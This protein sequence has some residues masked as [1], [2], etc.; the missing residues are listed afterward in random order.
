MMGGWSCGP[1]GTLFPVYE[2]DVCVPASV[3]VVTFTSGAVC[4][5]VCAHVCACSCVCARVCVWLHWPT[6]TQ[7]VC[8]FRPSPAS[9]LPGPCSRLAG[10][11]PFPDR[12]GCSLRTEMEPGSPEGNRAQRKGWRWRVVEALPAPPGTL[13]QALGWQLLPEPQSVLHQALRGLPCPQRPRAP[14][15]PVSPS[16]QPG[17]RG[18]DTRASETQGVQS[19][20]GRA[21]RRARPRLGGP[22]PWLKLDLT[23]RRRTPGPQG[24]E[25]VRHWGG[26]GLLPCA[27]FECRARSQGRGWWG[28]A[29]AE[30]WPGPGPFVF[31]I[32]PFRWRPAWPQTRRLCCFLCFCPHSLGLFHES[33][34]FVTGSTPCRGRGRAPPPARGL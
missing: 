24:G 16:Q 7:L 34:T 10:W 19:Q 32:L 27:G 20:P 3:C 28:G 25:C 4:M 15:Q 12:L 23:S 17:R 14:A 1:P 18:P 29:G 6:V 9:R 33:L 31:Q 11:S 26:G 22:G 13:C 8:E 21:P 30:R 2:G 5:C